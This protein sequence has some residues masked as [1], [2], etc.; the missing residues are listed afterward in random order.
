LF[1]YAQ[2]LEVL[3][4]GEQDIRDFLASQKMSEHSEDDKTLVIAVLKKG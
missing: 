2:E 3:E 4:E 1:S